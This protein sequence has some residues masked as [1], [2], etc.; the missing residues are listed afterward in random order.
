MRMKKLLPPVLLLSLASGAVLA[1][2]SKE[3]ENGGK[4]TAQAES[5]AI[6]TGYPIVKTK[7]NLKLV[8]A[9][10]PQQ[11][12][13]TDQLKVVQDMEQLTNI[14]INWDASDQGYQ[15][16]K[17]LMFASGDLPDAFFGSG[18]LTDSDILKY[19]TQGMLIPLE[20]LIDQYA[21]NI[22]KMLEKQPDVKK[23]ITAPD[24][25]IY[26]IPTVITEGANEL[27]EVL[28]V[29][30]QWLDKLGLSVPTTTAE[31]EQV[32]KAFKDKDLNGN[33]KKDEIPFSFV[34][35]NQLNGIFGL[36]GA[37]GLPD[38]ASHI[39][40]KDGKVS[41][42][43]TRPEFKEAT[44]YF[45][46][47][48]KQGLIDPE[49]FTQD[50]NVYFSKGRGKDGPVF[51]AFTGYNAEN[52]VGPENAKSYVPIAPLKGPQGHQLVNMYE[53]L[54]VSKM[55]FAITSSNKHVPETMRWID[56]VFDERHSVEWQFGPV[57]V[58]F[59]ETNGDKYEYLPTPAG[60]SY[61]D[62]RCTEAPCFGGTGAILEDTY[63]KIE[64]SDKIKTRLSYLQ[65]YQPFMKKHTLPAGMFFT[66]EDSDR[67]S[68]LDT[69]ITGYVKKKQSQWVIDGN[70]DA[71]WD[72]YLA[73][74]KKSGLDE[75]IQIYQRTYDRFQSIK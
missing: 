3:P 62:F 2:C 55:G 72:G 48:Y 57:G 14:H 47:L 74:L 12:K 4:S 17:N 37:F 6:G 13:S 24:G 45:H 70:I 26:S 21:P 9:K 56:T 18:S 34:N 49:A 10:T 53:I 65:I 31:F 52:V 33:G 51:G 32:L 27:G 15:E 30:K 75:F 54:A 46:S 29:N 7:L 71:E 11:K 5:E 42:I 16:K 64:L 58:N 28:F 69:D 50:R 66:V 40:Q 23:V 19:G 20:K 60:M 38:N 68:V 61:D 44:A 59:K 73:Q 39:M 41:Y 67:L 25:H 63:K 8:T 43:A 1:G 35:G 36:Y 22:K